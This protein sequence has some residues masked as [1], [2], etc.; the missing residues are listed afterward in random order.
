M[1]SAQKKILLRVTQVK[2]PKKHTD[3]NNAIL[4]GSE[5][6]EL[7]PWAGSPGS[8]HIHSTHPGADPGSGQG[9]DAPLWSHLFAAVEQ[10]QRD[11]SGGGWDPEPQPLAPW[12]RPWSLVVFGRGVMGVGSIS[13]W[14]HPWFVCLQE[15]QRVTDKGRTLQMYSGLNFLQKYTELNMCQ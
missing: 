8:V 12:T 14:F 11:F 13:S 6:A 2:T 15:T 10:N 9:R 3:K 1:T 4:L 5:N 7:E